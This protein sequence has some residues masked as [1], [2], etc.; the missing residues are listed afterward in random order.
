M[1][2]DTAFDFAK[3]IMEK[4]YKTYG[5]KAIGREEAREIFNFIR[6]NNYPLFQDLYECN[7]KRL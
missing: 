5:E 7:F 1:V 2:N 3:H 4:P 6:E